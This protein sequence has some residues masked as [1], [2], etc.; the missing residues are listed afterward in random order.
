MRQNFYEQL[1]EHYQS[2]DGDDEELIVFDRLRARIR[3]DL[4]SEK[5]EFS[6]G[7]FVV[8]TGP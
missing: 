5:N 3:V 8:G 1:I 4:D 6:E 7:Q 2:T